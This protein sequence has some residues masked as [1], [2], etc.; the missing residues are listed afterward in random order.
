MYKGLSV[1]AY[2]VHLLMQ[3]CISSEW[4]QT[5]APRLAMTTGLGSS[6]PAT[7]N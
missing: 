2:F 3:A 5:L 7:L 1:N 6:H 4:Q